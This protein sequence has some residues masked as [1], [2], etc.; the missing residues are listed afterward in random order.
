MLVFKGTFDQLICGLILQTLF[1]L[2]DF[3]TII[4]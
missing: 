4:W 1:S 2:S 3:T